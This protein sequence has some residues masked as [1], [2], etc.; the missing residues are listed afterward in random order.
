[1]PTPNGIAYRNVA[2]WKVCSK[3][4]DEFMYQRTKSDLCEFCRTKERKNKGTQ[5]KHVCE[6]ER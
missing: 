5:S 6:E 4:G 2:K 3:C 1:M